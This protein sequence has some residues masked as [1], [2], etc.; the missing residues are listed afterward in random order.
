MTTPSPAFALYFRKLRIDVH[1]DGFRARRSRGNHDHFP[2]VRHQIQIT[3]MRVHMHSA[4]IYPR[5]ATHD[6]HRQ[7]AEARS[8]RIEHLPNK[9]NAIVYVR[10]A[11]TLGKRA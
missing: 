2:L 5:R 3:A 9:R 1:N 4:Q 8:K 11:V 6:A 10:G 7:I